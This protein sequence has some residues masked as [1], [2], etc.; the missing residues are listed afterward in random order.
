[1]ATYK[2]IKGFK[3]QSLSADPVATAAWA[4]GGALNTGRNSGGGAGTATAAVV[5]GGA[6]D[7]GGY[8]NH[9]EEY[10]GT[11][12]TQG[13][14]YPASRTYLGSAGSQ[15]A[16]LFIAG[17]N[18]KS[19]E[20][21]FYNGTAY[22]ATGSKATAVAQG[23]ATGIQSAAI[24]C[25]GEIPALTNTTEEFSGSTWSAGGTM[26]TARNNNTCFGTATDA[27]TVGGS[28]AG[29]AATMIAEEYNG[30]AWAQTNIINNVR[31]NS[32]QPGAGTA[33][34]AGMIA[35]GGSPTISPEYSNSVEN[36]NGSTWSV[37][38]NSLS[39]KRSK[40]FGTRSPTGSY[41]VT[42]GT[43]GYITSTEIYS[44]NSEPNTFLNQGQ[45]WYNSTSGSLK[46]Y[47][48][49]TI[50]TVTVS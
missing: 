12:W 32:A 9:T 8:T 20:C 33:S 26:N 35:G 50:K 28:N 1:M 49:T 39:T 47:N 15:T 16:A 37:N 6:D 24:Y 30:V 2:A 46:Y 45:L 21:F 38:A 17:A 5:A 22:S 10:N 11:A 48:G 43:P 23:G 44:E 27:V 36:Y 31:E 25:G 7:P 34:T 42:G 29:A 3:T 14:N 41:L 40:P 13:T 4:T 18:P 19:A